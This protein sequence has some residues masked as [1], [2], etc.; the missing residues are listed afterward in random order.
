MIKNNIQANYLHHYNAIVNFS[1]N[2]YIAD[3]TEQTKNQAVHKAVEF[4]SP[5]PPV[6][7]SCFSMINNPKLLVDGIKFDNLSF[8]CS[9]G[10]TKK[11][12]EAVLFPSSSSVDSWILFCELKYSS[13]PVNNR[14]N[15]KK[16]IRQLYKT[17]HY[18]FQRNIFARTNNCYLIASLPLQSEPFT[19]FS[20]SQAQ[21]TKLKRTRNIILRMKNSVGITNA[22][23][24]AV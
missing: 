8:V 12:C 20:V 23:L 16:A 13:I 18:Y 17:Q 5:Q 9:S 11:Q 7:I 6:D 15:L 3:Y 19:H 22:E 1:E 4:L 10:K 21:L 14:N 2:I 24:L